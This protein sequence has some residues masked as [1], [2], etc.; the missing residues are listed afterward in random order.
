MG[1][2]A[3]TAQVSSSATVN[4]SVSFNPRS[5]RSKQARLR[6]YLS[7]YKG[8]L[9]WGTGLL[10]ALLGA[11]GLWRQVSIGRSAIG[12][13]TALLIVHIWNRWQ[14][15][16]LTVTRGRIDTSPVALDQVLEPALLAGI[17]WPTTPEHLWNM[18]VAQWQGQFVATRLGIPY[19]LVGQ[20]LQADESA[21]IWTEA[22][23]L[24]INGHHQEIDGGVL[25]AAILLS[26][27]SL[28]P[29]LIE[30]KLDRNDV[31][32]VLEWQQR[33]RQAM[34]GLRER[35]S[36]GGIGRDWASGFTPTLN[37]F[38]KNITR[39]VETGYYR[40][41]P[42]VHEGVVEQ[43][44]TQLATNKSSVALV[45]DVGSGK[46]ALVYSLAERL[47]KGDQA[48][49]LEYYCIMELNAS[50]LIS[51]GNRIENTVLQ[52]LAEAI[53]ARNIII[54]LDEA[55]L[56]FGSGTGSVD[57][58]KVLL[59]ILQQ[60]SLKL[61]L[62]MSPHDWQALASQSTAL[63]GSVQ[64]LV[65]PLANQPD[66]IKIME[67]AAI[68]I[69]HNS[70][71]TISY[72]AIREAYKLADRYMSESAFPG[73]GIALLES[74]ATRAENGLIT[75]LSV[76]LAVE[77]TIGTK[78]VSAG[79]AEKQQLLNLED[80]IHKR[81]INQSHAVKVVS[82]ALR[83]ARAGVRSPK[84]PV[85][86]FLFLGPTGVGKTELARSL[87]DIYFGG[88]NQIIR[89]DM[90]EYQQTS[91]LD[92]L[93]AA[94]SGS[95]AGSTLVSGIRKQ[96]FSVVLLDEIEKANPDILNLLLQILDEGRLTDSDGR[97]VSFK[98]AIIICTSN[99]SADLIREKISDGLKLEDFE[100]EITNSLVQGHQFRPEL[101]NRFDEI[102]LFR[103][104]DK[105]E[106]RQVVQLLLGEVNS[107]LKE[108]NISVQLTPA[109]IDWL[110]DAGYDPKLGARPMRRMV[111][112][113][114]ENVVAKQILAG[115]AQPGATVGL[116]VADLQ[117]AAAAE[118]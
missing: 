110:V 75:P 49:G 48:H 52:V 65:V 24:T 83:R 36:Y 58:S 88:E 32:S 108:Q 5:S 73:K 39:E 17:K 116:D 44:A 18:S 109:A 38:A 105:V 86:S 80:Q 97:A 67:D 7:G 57:L 101:V 102:V 112:R 20:L 50:M 95:S 76:Q 27:P 23:S 66:T 104:L 55:Q 47:I 1:T 113:V 74:A 91:D 22:V 85:G 63:S 29:A 93:L 54:F 8:D 35:P 60:S 14:L 30:L 42:Q 90:S 118:R 40:H 10:L 43:L 37:Q 82:D 107:H 6:R 77:A 70:N 106:L 72:E 117:A 51:A 45:G 111:Q 61:I 71:A 33:L 103:P 59:P 15:Q 78:V 64:R 79:A 114:V 13:A 84:R 11:L 100:E 87:A 3:V 96:P 53:H 115:S 2:A 68:G 56:F 99:A 19:D 94:S 62:A 81:M 26:A 12:L 92:R 41:L 46:T 34:I 98:D 28:K 21:D 9:I 25:V 69:E 16:P 31:I 4:S 89:L